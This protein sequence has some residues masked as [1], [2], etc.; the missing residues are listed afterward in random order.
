M[1]ESDCSMQGAASTMADV[2]RPSTR[3]VAARCAPAGIEQS[4]SHMVDDTHH[5]NPR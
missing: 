2:G 5:T 4:L 3:P 1:C